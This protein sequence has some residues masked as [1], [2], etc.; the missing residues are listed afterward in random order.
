MSEYKCTWCHKD[1]KEQD[2]DLHTTTHY[3]KQQNERNTNPRTTLTTVG[4]VSYVK[5]L[6]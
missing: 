1:V 4:S 3:A 6:G 2:F 5:E